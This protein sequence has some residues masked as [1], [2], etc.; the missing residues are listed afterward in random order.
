[1]LR[2]RRSHPHI[3][4]TPRSVICGPGGSP[5]V[6][7]MAKK[8]VAKA[9]LPHHISQRHRD[10]PDPIPSRAEY[11][12]RQIFVREGYVA[13][14]L[15]VPPEWLALS[16]VAGEFTQN[17]F[18]GLCKP[19]Q[20]D[21][22]YRGTLHL[23]GSRAAEA[24]KTWRRTVRNAWPNAASEPC[25]QKV[26]KRCRIVKSA[27]AWLGQFRCITVHENFRLQTVMLVTE[28]RP[29]AEYDPS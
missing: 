3:R 5:N 24:V 15:A 18:C 6:R 1:M 7:A 11:R 28:M 29:W 19:D 22:S 25:K 21:D 16:S 12:P 13:E 8:V 17:R 2:A 14:D 27:N 10:A 20:R 26:S 4:H 23:V 9:D